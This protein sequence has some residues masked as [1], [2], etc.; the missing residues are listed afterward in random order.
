MLPAAELAV[1]AVA[2]ADLADADEDQRLAVAPHEDCV[3]IDAEMGEDVSGGRR[4]AVI[5]P[6]PLRWTADGA[7][8]AS[9]RP[10]NYCRRRLA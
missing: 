10:E 8:A 5:G 9:R 1:A 6:A 3:P 2:V 7:L 4:A